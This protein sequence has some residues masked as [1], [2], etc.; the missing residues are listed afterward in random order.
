MK[1]DADSQVLGNNCVW[2][3]GRMYTEGLNEGPRLQ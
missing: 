2:L 3:S 1:K